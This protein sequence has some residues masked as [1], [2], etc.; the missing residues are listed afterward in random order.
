MVTL[1]SLFVSHGAPS[2]ILDNDATTAFFRKLGAKY[3]KPDGIVCI[4]AHWESPQLLLTANP[5]RETIYDFYG[6]PQPLYEIT[7]PGTGS[8]GLVEQVTTAL[9]TGNLSVKVNDKRGFDHGVWVPL[10]L[11]YPNADIPIVQLSVLPRESASYHY[12]IG[13]ALGSLRE[14][15]I[16]I[17]ASGS[18]THN[19]SEFRRQTKDAEPLDY[20]VAF[21]QW[22]VEKIESGDRQSLLNYANVAP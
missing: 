3:Q 14:Q 15:N 16:L 6:F 9:N 21:D 19:L 10:K 1:P 17:F 13:Q 11:M 4:S 18:A 2:L 8:T 7:Y 12:E 22:L 20:A 5:Q